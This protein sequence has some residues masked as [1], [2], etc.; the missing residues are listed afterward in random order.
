MLNAEQQL[1]A[2]ATQ[3]GTRVAPGVELGRAAQGLAAALVGGALS[4]L[5]YERDSG[6][7]VTLQVAQ[8]R[9]YRATSAEALSS[10]Q[11]QRNLWRLVLVDWR[12]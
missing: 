3:D 12:T 4:G 7:M 10:M 11:S 9:E 8:V 5:M 1:S 2:D 6:V